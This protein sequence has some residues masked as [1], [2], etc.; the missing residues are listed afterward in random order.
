MGRGVPDHAGRHAAWPVMNP[1]PIIA[2]AGGTIAVSRMIPTIARGQPSRPRVNA[3]RDRRAGLPGASRN[4]CGRSRGGPRWCPSGGT[5]SNTT[6]RTS[7][8]G[9]PDR[10]RYRDARPRAGVVAD[11]WQE[12][13]RNSR[14]RW[15]DPT[16]YYQRLTRLCTPRQRSRTARDRSP[17]RAAE[18]CETTRTLTAHPLASPQWGEQLSR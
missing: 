16:R 3:P 7:G 4:D 10:P 11:R 5:D 6:P 14:P 9:F 8:S 15:D 12:E 17:A 1:D 2:M 18:F 13:G